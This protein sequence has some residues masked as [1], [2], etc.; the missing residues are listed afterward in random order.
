MVR[1]TAPLL[2]ADVKQVLPDPHSSAA[3][4][5]FPA[6]SLVSRL[7]KSC[8]RTSNGPTRLLHFLQFF[9]NANQR[10]GGNLHWTL[11]SVINQGFACSAVAVNVVVE[12]FTQHGVPGPHILRHI[13]PLGLM[14][15]GVMTVC[16]G[17]Y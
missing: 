3:H 17:N 6:A 13:F 10:S 1:F 4:P 14:I 15:H 2:A 7:G 5:R 9:P 11:Y 8:R 12:L 16:G